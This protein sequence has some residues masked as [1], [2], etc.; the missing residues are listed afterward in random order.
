MAVEQ[1]TCLAQ[2]VFLL[3][4]QVEIVGGELL[5]VETEPRRVGE[6]LEHL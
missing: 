1:V 4:H 2:R 3:R 5:P 6:F